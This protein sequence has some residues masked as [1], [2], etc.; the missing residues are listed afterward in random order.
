MKHLY[1]ITGYTRTKPHTKVYVTFKF[2]KESL[3]ITKSKD[4]TPF[5]EIADGKQFIELQL[6]LQKELTHIK[7]ERR[8]LNPRNR[9]TQERI[10]RDIK[11]THSKV[12][13][14]KEIEDE[15]AHNKILQSI[16]GS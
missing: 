14:R 7:W 5:R 6:D 9:Q 10:E 4:P 8:V 3:F 1:R 16:F 2:Y 11:L 13:S 15:I 12:K